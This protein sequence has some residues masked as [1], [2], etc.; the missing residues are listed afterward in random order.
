MPADIRAAGSGAGRDLP[1]VRGPCEFLLTGFPH[2]VRASHVQVRFYANVLPR[3]VFD[4]SPC[5]RRRGKRP[6]DT[7]TNE[8]ASQVREVPVAASRPQKRRKAVPGTATAD[9][10]F[11]V[12]GCP[13]RA[14]GGRPDIIVMPTILRPLVHI[15]MEL[16]EAPWIRLK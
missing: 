3:S 10:E 15:A 8:D 4:C 12:S 11:T 16:I 7:K 5:R 2:V 13:C 14:V 1:S 6:R 9:P